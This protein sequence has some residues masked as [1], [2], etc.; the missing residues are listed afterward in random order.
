MYHLLEWVWTESDRTT[1]ATA[2][3]I[4][5]RKDPDKNPDAG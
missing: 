5:G 2:F 3:S 4:A 1:T